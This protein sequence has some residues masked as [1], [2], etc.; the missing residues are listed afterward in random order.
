MAMKRTTTVSFKININTQCNFCLISGFYYT[1]GFKKGIITPNSGSFKKKWGSKKKR[2]KLSNRN[3][4]GMGFQCMFCGRLLWGRT[5]YKGIVLSPVH[6]LSTTLV[7]SRLQCPRER[8]PAAVEI[9][10]VQRMCCGT[11]NNCLLFLSLT[12]FLMKFIDL[13]S[14]PCSL[15]S[16]SF[17]PP[18]KWLVWSR[19]RAISCNYWDGISSVS[20]TNGY[21]TLFVLAPATGLP[22]PPVAEVFYFLY[23]ASHTHRNISNCSSITSTENLSIITR[24]IFR[25]K[26]R[27]KKKK[28][29]LGEQS[30]STSQPLVFFREALLSCFV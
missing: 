6:R 2:C 17:V 7:P 14:N 12:C 10:H 20:M 8:C 3:V 16:T 11:R 18:L 26:E 13:Q 30:G 23:S 21:L 15:A 27:K 24:I 9:H 22:P 5:R 25:A 28:K 19:S 4:W 29:A 1:E